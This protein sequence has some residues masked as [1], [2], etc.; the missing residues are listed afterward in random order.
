MIVYMFHYVLE[1]DKY[2]H[3]DAKIFEEHVRE[4]AESNRIINMDQFKKMIYNKDLEN[5]KILLTFDDGTVDHYDV[6]YPI[7]KK[8]GVSGIFFISSNVLRRKILDVQKI[9]ALLREINFEDLNKKFNSILSEMNLTYECDQKNNTYDSKDEKFLKQMLQYRLIKTQRKKVINR[10]IKY[11]KIKIKFD[12]IYL[13]KKKIIEMK[14]NGMYF[15]IHTVNHIRLS[16]LSRENQIKEI[17]KCKKD[18]LSARIIDDETLIFSYPYG[19]YNHETIKILQ[20]LGIDLAFTVQEGVITGESCKSIIPRVD[21]K[22]I[23]FTD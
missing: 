16:L 2:H 21:C 19:D 4:W 22:K 13:N 7:L 10:L 23:L 6:V 11:F 20:E 9:H 15:G 18:I 12:K 3:F 8:Y 14:K 5:D 17:K 1:E